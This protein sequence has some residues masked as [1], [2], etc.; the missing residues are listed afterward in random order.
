MVKKGNGAPNFLHKNGL[1]KRFFVSLSSPCAALE[2]KKEYVLTR[3]VFSTH[4][5]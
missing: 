3:N 5:N 2:Y 1:P 4:L